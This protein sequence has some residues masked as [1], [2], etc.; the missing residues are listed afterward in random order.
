M[1]SIFL[2]LLVF[3]PTLAMAHEIEGVLGMAQHVLFSPH[4]GGIGVFM[5][6][7]LI[8]LGV[9][10]AVRKPELSSQVDKN[11]GSGS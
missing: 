7:G 6:I 9:S 8:Y 11:S 4:H 3:Y 2:A 10:R 1:R 5:V